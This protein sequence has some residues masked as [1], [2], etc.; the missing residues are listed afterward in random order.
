MRKRN[1]KPRRVLAA[2]MSAAMIVSAMPVSAL[3]QEEAV[4]T[5][6]AVAEEPAEAVDLQEIAPEDAV[7]ETAEVTAEAA[8]EELAL[9]EDGAESVLEE[10]TEEEEAAGDEELIL[11]EA[12]EA[13]E[14]EEA[15][16]D[17]FEV[18]EET[19]VSPEVVADSGEEEI[20]IGDQIWQ[21]I[22]D[23][24]QGYGQM[25]P[26]T[27]MRVRTRLFCEQQSADDLIGENFE[28]Y[29][30]RVRI[31]TDEEGTPAYDTEL[32]R[33]TVDETQK[34]LQVEAGEKLG[35]TSVPLIFE[36]EDES[37]NWQYLTRTGLYISV[38]DDY[39]ALEVEGDFRADLLPGETEE[40]KLAVY[41]HYI[42]REQDEEGNTI[43]AT[44]KKERVSRVRYDFRWT[45]YSEDESQPIARLGIRRSENEAGDWHELLPGNEPHEFSINDEIDAPVEGFVIEKLRNDAGGNVR[46]DVWAL[47]CNEDGSPVEDEAG[48]WVYDMLGA[49]EWN[50]NSVDLNLALQAGQWQENEDGP[51]F[52]RRM[53][54]DDEQPR[55]WLFSDEKELEVR[56][57]DWCLDSIPEQ[58]ELEWSLTQWRDGEEILLADQEDPRGL[59]TYAEDGNGVLLQA[60]ALAGNEDIRSNGGG[61]DV[62]AALVK[63]GRE[64]T[65]RTMLCELREA[66]YRVEL[67]FGGPSDNMLLPGEW[68]NI[69]GWDINVYIKNAQYPEGRNVEKKLQDLRI[70]EQYHYET[71][72]QTGEPVKVPHA[73][74]DPVVKLERFQ[75]DGEE[76]GHPEDEAAEDYS[77]SLTAVGGGYA[78]V[79]Y[80]L[81]AGE[82]ILTAQQEFGVAEEIWCPEFYHGSGSTAM[83]RNDE[84]DIQTGLRRR[85]LVSENDNSWGEEQRVEDYRVVLLCDEKG[86][87]LYDP[88]LLDVEVVE[89][90][91]LKVSSGQKLGDAW[92][93]LSYQVLDENHEWQEVAQAWPDVQVRD[94]YYQ[95]EPLELDESTLM[96]GQSLTV[97]P[98][99]MYYFS[100]MEGEYAVPFREEV[101]DAVFRWNW[102][103]DRDEELSP[104]QL[105]WT[106]ENGEHEIVAYENEPVIS[107]AEEYTFTKRTWRPDMSIR[108]DAGIQ[109][110]D[111]EGNP[112]VDPEGNPAVEWL[113]NREWWIVEPDLN[114]GELKAGQVKNGEWADR[115]QD[116]TTAVFFG[117]MLTV[118]LDPE[119]LRDVDL[120]ES[121]LVLDWKLVRYVGEEGALELCIEPE[122]Y[123][124]FTLTEDGRGIEINGTSLVE[125]LQERDLGD[126]LDIEVCLRAGEE[127]RARSSMGCYAGDPV[128]EFHFPDEE[129]NT[130]NMLPGQE[131]FLAEKDCWFYVR[132]PKYPFGRE[133]T[134]DF[135]EAQVSTF[136]WQWDEATQQDILVPRPEAQPAAARIEQEENGLRLIAETPGVA[137]ILALFVPQGEEELFSAEFDYQIG[138]ERYDLGWWNPDCTDGM[139]MQT[140]KRFETSLFHEWLEE[141][142][143]GGFEQ[144]SEDVE[145]YRIRIALNQE[146]EP[147]YRTDLISAEVAEDGKTLVIRSHDQFGDTQVGIVAEVPELDEQGQIRT[148]ENGQVIWCE[149]MYRE[150]HVWVGDQMT[151]LRLTAD[152]AYEDVIPGESITISAK[153]IWTAGIGDRIEEVE[154][155]SAGIDFRIVEEEYP[156]FELEM[157][158]QLNNLTVTV[159]KMPEEAENTD[160]RVEVTAFE[161]DAEGQPVLNERGEKCIIANNEYWIPVRRCAHPENKIE[162]DQAVEATCTSTGLTAGTHC[163]RCGA[164]L[165]AQKSVAKKDHTVVTVAGKAA[166]YIAS[167]LTE[168]K[169]CSVCKQVLSAQQTIAPKAKTDLSKC[170]VKLSKTRLVYTGKA[171]KPKVTVSMGKTVIS[172]TNYQISYA[173]NKDIGK[174]TIT[175]TAKGGDIP[176]K[177]SV[178]VTF[179]IV[180]K[181]ATIS[182]AKN[183]GTRAISVTW[184]KVTPASGYEIECKATNSTKK[185][186]VSGASKRAGKV[187]GLVKGKSYKVRIRAYKTVKGKKYYGD[188]SATKTVKVK[189]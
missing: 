182:S 153:A 150:V 110:T 38:M 109:R 127:E 112:E 57:E 34:N 51:F 183:D 166:T 11:D 7:E 136:D 43:C 56:L 69:A 185:V 122:E 94:A 20:Q 83:L 181:K 35:G 148:D 91:I 44:P 156:G 87:P 96:P 9:E 58:L 61:F 133:F 67:P 169:Y 152:A 37:G 180:P 50:L 179:E 174:A 160:I 157:T 13:E 84:M 25:L 28:E 140:E 19:E 18:L 40:F 81:E 142:P 124:I 162:T 33:I 144:R 167:G 65:S 102:D 164:V 70:V 175:I 126:W 154:L 99:L 176:I 90:K 42:D 41:R 130:R 10:A 47:R 66:E 105:S 106:D 46:V 45:G 125:F 88:E 131:R 184:K 121:G 141:T 17:G 92:I 138:T 128:H 31:E 132:D 27:R 188:W 63:D 8:Q 77:W 95:V 168:G 75:M 134:I 85:W 145:N 54:W 64:L 62:K 86:D 49:R 48:V 178:K 89:E 163:G 76:G 189:R 24:E 5:E 186:R 16:P 155:A 108:L 98:R 97:S 117:E 1:G 3:A 123:G 21:G 36:K 26:G 137:R 135:R 104:V 93:G 177:G 12:F 6:N 15:V 114:L 107:A 165:T 170:K 172:A 173:G 146:G 74:T 59:F 2:I 149:V 161:T 100:A 118:R 14:L 129:E 71:D 23:Y 32:I 119:T 82:Q 111:A 139:L 55:T 171:Q 60:A 68:R 30:Y 73:D 79:E 4:W 158:R 113:S 187:K 103:A 29:Q 53:F 116:N 80:T 39:L 115:L 101:K 78:L 147:I 143:E 120:E 22:C 151:T 159:K 52:E 72:E